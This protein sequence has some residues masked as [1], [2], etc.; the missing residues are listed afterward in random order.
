MFHLV[1]LT[2]KESIRLQTGAVMFRQNTS[3]QELKFENIVIP[4]DSFIV[5]HMGDT[6]FVPELYKK[7]GQI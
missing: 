4:K 5:Y 3:G 2:F 1:N 6:Y 7:C